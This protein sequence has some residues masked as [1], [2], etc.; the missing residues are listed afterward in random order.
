MQK[1]REKTTLGEICSRRHRRGGKQRRK[2]AK[3][4]IGEGWGQGGEARGREKPAKKAAK[5]T[6]KKRRSHYFFGGLNERGDSFETLLFYFLDLS[7]EETCCVLI[8]AGTIISNET[9]ED[10]TCLLGS[11]AGRSSDRSGFRGIERVKGVILPLGLGEYRSY[12]R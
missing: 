6:Q 8:P 9:D 2:P 7:Q 11:G 4:A 3:A 12:R 10:R 5:K 1:G